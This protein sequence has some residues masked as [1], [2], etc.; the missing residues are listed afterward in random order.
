MTYQP[1][2]RILFPTDLSDCAESAYT[3]AAWLADRFGATLYVL[4]VREDP[5]FPPPDWAQDIEV[6][7][8]DVAEDLGLPLAPEADPLDVVDVVYD[9]VKASDVAA[10]ILHRASVLPADLV[11]M[12]THGR[13]GLGRAL[14]GS[15]AESVMRHARCPVLTVRPGAGGEPLAFQQFLV[16]METT[17]PVPPEAMWGARL[18]RAYRARLDLLRVVPLTMLHPGASEAGRRAHHDLRV[19]EE[20]LLADGVQ[21]ASRVAEGDPAEVIARTAGE[22]RADM[23]VLG[24]HGRE[25][26]RR[27]ILGSVSE[28]VIRIAP[29]PVFVA[30][31]AA[32]PVA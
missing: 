15:V 29:C 17:D 20:K 1:I 27:A 23:V 22:I 13:S 4:H 28:A 19:L 14:L 31:R 26:V 5:G 12:G 30:R 24:S 7:T 9:E 6:T 21:A 10:A 11:V 8:G 25:G 2:R 16:A 18:A 32:V 3:H